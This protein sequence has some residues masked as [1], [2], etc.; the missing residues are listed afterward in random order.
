MRI[1]KINKIEDIAEFRNDWNRIVLTSK[2][3]TINHAFDWVFL[4]YKHFGN[5]KDNAL[6][7]LR[8]GTKIVGFVPLFMNTRKTGKILP[9]KELS[10]IGVA[11]HE[12][13]NF[14]DFIVDEE[15]TDGIS[16][17]FDHLLK[18][19]SWHALQLKYLTEAGSYFE[20]LKK[21]L[22]LKGV[23][24]ATKI[25]T[26]VLYVDLKSYGSWENYYG[27]LG[28]NLRREL[29]KRNYKFE[30]YDD[31]RY[32][33]NPPVEDDELFQV[34]RHL[35]TKRQKQLG[36]K[37]FSEAV[38]NFFSE[39]ISDFRKK[40]LLD[41][42]LIYVNGKPISYTLGFKF[43]NIYYHESIGFDPD[44]EQLSPN[45]VHHKLLIESCFKDGLDE[46]NFMRGDSDYKF[47]WTQTYRNSYQIRLANPSSFYGKMLRNIKTKLRPL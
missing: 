2:H 16:F 28:R 38:W 6:Y 17:F 23:D 21:T 15:Y 41:F 14:C 26:K 43:K 20:T 35:Y 18:E 36:R 34:I 24:H 22:D 7:V 45:K 8:D 3:M 13:T 9:W 5:E 12:I 31:Y 33:R 10:F 42:S 29:T 19:K 30:E 46:F 4:L 11:R 44:Y 47:K 32:V 25:V 37:G 40:D 39:F 1:T 27:S